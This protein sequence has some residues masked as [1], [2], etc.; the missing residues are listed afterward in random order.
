MKFR[1]ALQVGVLALALA[2]CRVVMHGDRAAIG[3]GPEQATAQARVR[4]QATVVAAATASA[5]TAGSG[6]ACECESR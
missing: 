1:V 4:I 6:Q 3:G 2:G 5:G